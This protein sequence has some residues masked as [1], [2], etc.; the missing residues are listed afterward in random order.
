MHG[1][2]DS[3]RLFALITRHIDLAG[4][5]VREGITTAVR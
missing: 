1:D 3:E 2:T 4:G 5:D